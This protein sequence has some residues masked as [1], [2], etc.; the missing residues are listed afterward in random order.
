MGPRVSFKSR[1]SN[2]GEY[3]MR[4]S[5]RNFYGGFFILAAAAAT[6]AT[7]P[8]TV[9]PWCSVAS[10]HQLVRAAVV[11]S[12]TATGIPGEAKRCYC[13]FRCEALSRECDRPGLG[14]QLPEDKMVSRV[15]AK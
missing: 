14:T 2:A 4:H 7:Y 10:A 9:G 13:W 15:E 1:I 6:A 5:R 8:A 12:R 11:A 3:H